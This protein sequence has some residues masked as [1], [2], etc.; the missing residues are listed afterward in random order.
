M[1]WRPSRLEA[2]LCILDTHG[3]DVIAIKVMILYQIGHKMNRARSS[4]MSMAK[5]K[6]VRG[7]SGYHRHLRRLLDSFTTIFHAKGGL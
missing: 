4:N 2:D 7:Y 3:K 5:D 1:S 6:L